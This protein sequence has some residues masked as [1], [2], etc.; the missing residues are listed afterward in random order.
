MKI[1]EEKI[2]RLWRDPKF[3]GSYRG[4]KTFQMFLKT[5]KNIDVPEKELYKIIRKDPIYLMHLQAK[6]VIRRKYFLSNIGELIQSDLAYMYPFKNYKYFVVFIDCFS[7]KIFTEAIKN[8]KSETVFKVFQ[9]YLIE[10]SE[11]DKLETDQGTEYSLCKNYCKKNGILFHYKTGKNKAN[12]AEYAILQIKKRLYKMMRGNLTKDWPF[13]L[14]RIQEDFNNT[15]RKKLGYYCPNDIRNRYDSYFINKARASLK[16]K[17][18][19]LP[20]IEQQIANE[21]AFKNNKKALKPNDF[22]YLNL[23]QSIFSK[24][25]DVQVH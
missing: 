6:P 19:V 25:F 23:K 24:S 7:F 15:P 10:T 5:D 9:N 13:Y 21:E 8:K 2:L 12:F 20:S 3:G 16:L 22:V 14:K 11:I 4:I 1:S 18:I 17:Q